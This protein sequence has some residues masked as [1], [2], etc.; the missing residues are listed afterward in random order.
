MDRNIFITVLLGAVILFGVMMMFPGGQPSSGPKGMPWQIEVMADGHSKVF[1]LVLGKST[2][3]DAQIAVG[4][5][6]TVSLFQSEDGAFAVE[7]FFDRISTNGLK[8]RMVVTADLSHEQMQGMYDRG[9]RMANMG[10]GR[11]KVT[12]APEDLRTVMMTPIFSITYIPSINLDGEM[13]KARFGEPSQRLKEQKDE[14]SPL[15]EHWLYPRQGLDVALH[16]DGK[17]VL[18]YV[19][20]A[21]FGHL[22]EP[23]KDLPLILD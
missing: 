14:E 13:L 7:G 12:L 17:E 19:A 2:F 18:Q 22:S 3:T 23:L 8:A 6:V 5:N 9:I 21:N 10:G 4:E 1:G 20:P 15:T 11:H 16:H